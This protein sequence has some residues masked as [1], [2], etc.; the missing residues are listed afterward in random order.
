MKPNPGVRRLHS[1]G[2]P[3]KTDDAARCRCNAGYEAS[4]Y[5]KSAGR[6]IRKTFPTAA[7]AARTWRSDA[8]H[9]VR[10][11]T[12]RAVEPTTVNEAADTL[13]AE[14]ENGSIRTRSGD[15]YKPSAIRAYREVLDLHVRDDLGAMRLGDLRRR[16]VQRLTDRLVADGCSPSTIRNAL[17]PLRVI[18]RRALRDGLAAVNPCENLD[19]PAN[20]SARVEIVSAQHAATL[21]DALEGARDRALWATAFYAGLPR[22]ADGAPLARRRPRQ[23]RATRRA[24]LRPE[25]ARLRRAEVTR[26]AP[27]RSDCGR[28]SRAPA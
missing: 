16:H 25:G 10:R 2:C 3:A 27:V 1:T 13:I 17:M 20:R 26:R 21:V 15:P 12:V 19:L 14:M 5:D 23:R 8:A 9:G 24:I 11:G 18:F 6:K 7:A 28:A 4:V 22:R